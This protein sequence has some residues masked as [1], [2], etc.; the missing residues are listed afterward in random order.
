MT[1]ITLA[2][3][4]AVRGSGNSRQVLLVASTYPNHPK[5]LW[6]LPGG[7]QQAGEL[8]TETVA[9]EA[10]E[11]TGLRVSVGRLAYLAESYDDDVHFLSAAF[12]VTIEGDAEPHA[13]AAPGADHVV[14]AAW[15]PLDRIASRIVVGVVREPL[16]AYLHG[17]LGQRYAGVHRAGITIKWPTNS[18]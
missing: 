16:L 9:R 6:N 7:R 13:P 14:T 11:E 1:Q 10:F 12:D 2:A 3:G 18:T 4:L 8:L 15:V 17:E 5:P